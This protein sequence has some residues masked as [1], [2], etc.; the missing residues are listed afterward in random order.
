M[1]SPRP[2]L[3][4]SIAPLGL[5]LCLGALACTPS[6]STTPDP[7][8]PGPTEP[9]TTEPAAPATPEPEATTTPPTDG[10]GEPASGSVALPPPN[11][12]AWNT[13]QSDGQP[14]KADRGITD[15]QR[16]IQDNREKFRSCYDA[17]LA[18]QDGIK[19]RVTLVW[20][21]DPAGAVRDGAHIDPAA[22]DF[23]NDMLEK[24][25]AAALKTLTFPPSK[26][27]MD[28]TVRYPFDFQPK[29]RPPSR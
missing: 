17:A 25:M 26:R 21:L 9:G 24:C 15:Y 7:G 14:G 23:Q 8:A 29:G 19:G 18:K 12:S 28:S 16:I 1:R 3:V 22:S 13:G 27:G 4:A 10:T 20:V 2:S 6:Q 11:A 5:A